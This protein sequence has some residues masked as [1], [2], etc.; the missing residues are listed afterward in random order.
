[1]THRLHPFRSDE[2]TLT[3]RDLLALALGRSLVACGLV[4]RRAR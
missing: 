1:M 4:V 2:L 3:W